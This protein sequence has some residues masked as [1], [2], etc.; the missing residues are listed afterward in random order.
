MVERVCAFGDLSAAATSYASIY[1]IRRFARN[2][3][4]RMTDDFEYGEQ[5]IINGII[6]SFF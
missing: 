5:K 3:E 6:M 4:N 1:V 2:M